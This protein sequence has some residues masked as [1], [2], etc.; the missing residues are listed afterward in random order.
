MWDSDSCLG[1]LREDGGPH[2]IHFQSSQRN[3]SPLQYPMLNLHQWLIGIQLA[4]LRDVEIRQSCGKRLE[5]PC[6]PRALGHCLPQA[7][8]CEL[9]VTPVIAVTSVSGTLTSWKMASSA[10][11]GRLAQSAAKICTFF[12][13]CRSF[14]VLQKKILCILK[15]EGEKL[16]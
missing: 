1:N 14:F 4:K 9:A 3:C 12:C 13:S 10:V 16:F 8:Q 15:A 11:M 2:Q 7:P 6:D 5:P